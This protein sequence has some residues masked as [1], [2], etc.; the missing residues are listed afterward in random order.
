MSVWVAGGA[1]PAS[2]IR[3]GRRFAWRKSVN[4]ILCRRSS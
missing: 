2:Y 3:I 4:L 1:G